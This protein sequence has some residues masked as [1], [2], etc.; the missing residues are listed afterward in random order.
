MI[1][2]KNIPASV[3][4]SRVYGSY[5]RRAGSGQNMEDTTPG[6]R[7]LLYTNATCSDPIRFRSEL[8]KS[9]IFFIDDV[10]DKRIWSTHYMNITES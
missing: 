8:G 1:K 5:V 10:G 7:Y 9:Q 6:Y 3:V 2:I 4:P